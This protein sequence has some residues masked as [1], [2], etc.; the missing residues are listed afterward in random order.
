MFILDEIQKALHS[1]NI[2]A[3]DSVIEVIRD[4][5]LHFDVDVK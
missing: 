5:F 3:F 4:F 2:T 1:L